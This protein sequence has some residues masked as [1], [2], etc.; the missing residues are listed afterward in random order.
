MRTGAGHPHPDVQICMMSTRCIATIAGPRDNWAPAGDNLFIDMDLSPANLPPG[1]RL[2]LGTAEL[3]VTAGPH[4]GCQ[5]FIARYGRDACV[6]VN[7]GP[8]KALRLRGI[9]A[10]VARDGTVRL[11]DRARKL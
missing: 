1:S 9:Y 11:G 8:G 10:R 5:G 6:F 4:G 7:T 2:Q 3:E